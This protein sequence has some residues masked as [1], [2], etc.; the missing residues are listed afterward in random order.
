ME[1]AGAEESARALAQPLALWMQLALSRLSRDAGAVLL[2]ATVLLLPAAATALRSL[3]QGPDSA[4]SAR[5]PPI[6]SPERVFAEPLNVCV[7][8]IHNFGI[9]CAGAPPLLEQD[10]EHR[11][12]RNGSFCGY[13]VDVWRCEGCQ[14]IARLIAC[15]PRDTN[16]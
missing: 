2:V 9:S 16:R 3:Q 15:S 4:C 7:A 12:P 10:V 6:D 8:S 11:C 14:Y 1:G 5:T 13:D